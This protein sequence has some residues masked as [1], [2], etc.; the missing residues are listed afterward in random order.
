MQHKL[1][2]L[3]LYHPL[4]YFLTLAA[5]INVAAVTAITDAAAISVS[6]MNFKKFVFPYFLFT[7]FFFSFVL[8]FRFYPKVLSTH[9]HYRLPDS[10]IYIYPWKTSS[11]NHKHKYT[12]KHE[13]QMRKMLDG[14]HIYIKKVELQ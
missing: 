2:Y 11:F 9:M 8:V 7:H 6:N 4:F 5:N 13:W 3:L 1:L 10:D 12:F 14:I